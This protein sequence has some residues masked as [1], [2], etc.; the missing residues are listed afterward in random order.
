M[1]VGD[2]EIDDNR[3]EWIVVG[4]FGRGR[5]NRVRRNSLA[6]R[7]HAQVSPEIAKSL[8]EEVDGSTTATTSA[9]RPDT[10]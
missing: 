5:T 8:A 9:G 7:I 2:I 6:H 3:T 10:T 4:I 1:K